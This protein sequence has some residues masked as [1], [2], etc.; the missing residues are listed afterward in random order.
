MKRIEITRNELDA[1]LSIIRF[2]LESGTGVTIKSRTMDGEYFLVP[3]GE[4]IEGN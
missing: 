1:L 3:I 4:T 2:E